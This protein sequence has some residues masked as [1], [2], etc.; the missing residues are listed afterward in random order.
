M[1]QGERLEVLRALLKAAG[2]QKQAAL[3]LGI[4]RYTLYRRLDLYELIIQNDPEF[5]AWDA[6]HQ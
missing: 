6:K 3:I 5:R 1:Y 2:N 4:S